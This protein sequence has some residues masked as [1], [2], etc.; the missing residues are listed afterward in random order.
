MEDGTETLRWMSWKKC[1]NADEILSQ[2]Y[3][4]FSPSLRAKASNIGSHTTF[5]PYHTFDWAFFLDETSSAKKPIFRGEPG[6][7]LHG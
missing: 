4:S 5:S 1:G 7:H 3:A 2:M 6:A